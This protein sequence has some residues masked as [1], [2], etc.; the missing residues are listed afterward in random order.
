MNLSYANPLN[1]KICEKLLKIWKK[2][3]TC[4]RFLTLSVDGLKAENN[5]SGFFGIKM[6]SNSQNIIIFMQQA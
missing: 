1:K 5:K 4:E 2:E 3:E 6:L